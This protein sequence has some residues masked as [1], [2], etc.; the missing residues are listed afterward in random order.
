MRILHVIPSLSPDLGGPPQVAMN[1]VHALRN[2]SVDAE[3]AT[4]DFG[5][6]V[7]DYQRMDYV[8]DHDHNL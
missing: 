4:T 5:L 3:I 6:D 1:L 2:L 7:P 8:F